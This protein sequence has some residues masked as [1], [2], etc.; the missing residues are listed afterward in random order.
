MTTNN[1]GTVIQQPLFGCASCYE[2][3][4]YP[5]DHLHVYNGE[6]WCEICWDEVT[7]EIADGL[8]WSKLEPFKPAL[9]AECE[10]LRTALAE[11]RANDRQAMAYLEAVREIVGGDSFPEMIGRVKELLEERDQLL[12]A[13]RRLCNIY[14]VDGYYEGEMR[15]KLLDKAVN[16]AIE[17]GKE[18]QE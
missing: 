11:S 13:I 2:D 8:D 3:V 9:Q 10:E 17:R 15:E 7:H 4:S 5:A 1:P 12:A 6:C 16:R 18:K 14:V